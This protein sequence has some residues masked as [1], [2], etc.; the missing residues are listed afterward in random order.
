MYETVVFEN[1]PLFTTAN[2]DPFLT[3]VNDPFLNNE[4]KMKNET[5]I[6]E[7][8]HLK[9]ISFFKNGGFLK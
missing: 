5:I 7:N 4:E 1:D 6:F 8:D 9:K 2:E 3:I